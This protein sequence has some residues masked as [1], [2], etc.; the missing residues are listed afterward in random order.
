MTLPGITKAQGGTPTI[1]RNMM[2]TKYYWIKE[3]HNPQLGVYYV[4]CGQ[5]PVK[6]AKASELSL[7]GNNYM[8]RFKTKDLYEARLFELISDGHKIYLS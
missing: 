3:R 6:Q 4:A 7:Y 1:T 5:M 8:H 2:A